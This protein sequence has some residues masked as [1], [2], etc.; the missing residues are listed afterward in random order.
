MLGNAGEPL[1]EQCQRCL[2]LERVKSHRVEKQQEHSPQQRVDGVDGPGI[3]IIC[4]LWGNLFIP[5]CSP[6]SN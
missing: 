5:Q 1:Q 6:E 4:F 2:S 3:N